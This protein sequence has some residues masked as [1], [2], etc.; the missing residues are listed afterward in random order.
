MVDINKLELEVKNYVL[1][2][3]DLYG[4]YLDSTAGFSNNVRMIENAQ[5]Q[6]RSPGTDLDEL[7]IYYTNAS[8]ND[9][10]NQ[11]QHQTTQGNCKRRNATGG[12]NFLRAAQILIVLIF[13]YWDSEY[14]N[15][16]AAALGYEDASELKIPLIGDIRLL[17]QDIIHH[18]SIITAKT[19]KRLE[20]ITG[21]SV[22]SELSLATFQVESLLRDVKECLDELVVKAGGKDPEHRKIWHVQ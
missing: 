22:N 12:K 11:M 19:I 15:R 3:D 4:H 14:R 21:L 20:V 9:P 10:K 5:N 8:P 6:I 16:I 1:V 2:V 7:I 17:R 18:Q 13:E